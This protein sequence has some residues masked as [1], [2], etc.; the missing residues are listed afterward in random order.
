MDIDSQDDALLLE[1]AKQ[2]DCADRL[3]LVVLTDYGLLLLSF[4]GKLLIN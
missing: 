4:V 3:V 2:F 1:A